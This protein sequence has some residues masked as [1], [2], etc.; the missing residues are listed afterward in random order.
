MEAAFNIEKVEHTGKKKEKGQIYPLNYRKWYASTL[1]HT[2]GTLLPYRPKIR[3]YIPFILT[4]IH[5]SQ[6]YPSTTFIN[7]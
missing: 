1:R 4:D 2:F 5:V 6:S 7:R 3:A